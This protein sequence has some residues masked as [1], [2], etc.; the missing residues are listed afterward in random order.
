MDAFV[1]EHA[2]ARYRERVAPS[3]SVSEARREVRELARRSTPSITLPDCW[4]QRPARGDKRYFQ[5]EDVALVGRPTGKSGWVITTVFRKPP[6]AM[7]EAFQRARA[8]QPVD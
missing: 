4:R 5:C 6:T 2:A 3:L 7:E 1:T 8:M